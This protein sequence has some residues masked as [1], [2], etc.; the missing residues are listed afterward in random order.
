MFFILCEV[1]E[2]GDLF[3]LSLYLGDR[4]SFSRSKCISLHS[5][6]YAI[7][8]RQ[9]IK[10]ISQKN[11]QKSYPALF[12]I[13]HDNVFYNFFQYVKIIYSGYCSCLGKE[14]C[15]ET[16]NVANWHFSRESVRCLKCFF[17]LPFCPSKGMLEFQNEL[18][19]IL[20]PQEVTKLE[21]AKVWCQLFV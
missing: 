7:F 3:T 10:R 11:G 14:I 19:Y 15:Y 6:H 12:Q 2:K 18:L 9:G 21:I 4:R 16:L 13:H 1:W 17:C 8:V 20:L 5:I